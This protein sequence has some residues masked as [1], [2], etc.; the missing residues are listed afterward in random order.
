MHP[1]PYGFDHACVTP[2]GQFQA[3]QFSIQ[4]AGNEDASSGAEDYACLSLR[5]TGLAAGMDPR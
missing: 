5:H 4:L 2:A 1:D 3:W